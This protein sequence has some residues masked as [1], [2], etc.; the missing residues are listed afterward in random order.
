LVGLHDTFGDGNMW[1]SMG[2][3]RIMCR[4]D[5]GRRLSLMELNLSITPYIKKWRTT[6]SD[7]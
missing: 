1:K 2:L 7:P 4:F 6:E 5:N 3:Y